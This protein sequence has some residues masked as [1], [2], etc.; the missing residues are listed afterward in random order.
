MKSVKKIVLFVIILVIV[1]VAVQYFYLKNNGEANTSILVNTSQTDSREVAHTLY[2]VDGKAYWLSF[3]NENHDIGDCF[4]IRYM[5]T[6]PSVSKV[7]SK[8]T[9]R[10]QKIQL[11]FGENIIRKI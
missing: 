9:I 2:F 3:T 11:F 10:F 7:I 5:K 1:I 6:F 4:D 8:K